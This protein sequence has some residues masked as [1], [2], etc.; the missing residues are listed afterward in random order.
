[1]FFEDEKKEIE[2]CQNHFNLQ[3]GLIMK[4]RKNF[5]KSA[6]SALGFGMMLSSPKLVL[7]AKAIAEKK[8]I[9]PL[10]QP[11]LASLGGEIF[12]ANSIMIVSKQL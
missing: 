10:V 5:L 9:T 3:G 1:M 4:N 2:Q 6:T 12:S 7:A 11:G 8:K